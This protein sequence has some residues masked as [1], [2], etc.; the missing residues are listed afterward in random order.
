MGIAIL[1]LKQQLYRNRLRM[2]FALAFLT[3]LAV[4]GAVLAT[5]LEEDQQRL[6]A[7]AK[8]RLLTTLARERRFLAPAALTR[9]GYGTTTT[10]KNWIDHIEDWIWGTT[11]TTTTTT[12]PTTTTTTTTTTT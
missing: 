2:K 3:C 7:A 12:T 8:K 10:D 6:L 5:P 4:V 11:T 1:V 9:S